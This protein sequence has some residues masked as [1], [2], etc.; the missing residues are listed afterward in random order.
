LTSTNLPVVSRVEKLLVDHGGW[1]RVGVGRKNN[2]GT[3]KFD[4]TVYLLRIFLIWRL[5]RST[6]I[7]AETFNKIISDLDIENNSVI[8]T[9]E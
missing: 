4:F 8:V 9:T 5:H 7:T 1:K 3:W 2:K 6:A